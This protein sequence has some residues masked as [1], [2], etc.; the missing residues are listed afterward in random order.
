MWNRYQW[1][2]NNALIYVAREV[3]S[4]RSPEGNEPEMKTQSSPSRVVGVSFWLPPKSASETETWSSYLQSWVLTIRQTLTN[5][6]FLGHGGLIVKRYWIWKAG[7]EK[8]QSELWTDS[9]GYYFCNVVAVLPGQQ[10]KGIGRKLVEVVTEQADREG[11]N[12]YLESSKNIPNVQIY[13]SFGF[14]LVR[15]MACDD[16]GVVC[17]VRQPDSPR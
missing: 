1:G 14:K 3:G 6:R 2:I 10:G 7:Q 11:M 15:D 8:V 16:D 13:E 9:R 4:Q 5:I 17:K 12:C